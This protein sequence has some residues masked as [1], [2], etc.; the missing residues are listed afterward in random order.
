MVDTIEKAIEKAEKTGDSEIFIIG[1]AEIYRECMRYAN[2][3]Y[4]TEIY[5]SFEGDAFFPE[6]DKHQWKEIN[7]IKGLT[8]EKNLYNHDFVMFEKIS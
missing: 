4:L 1:G 2:R 8:D 3:I 7:R 6:V 5:H